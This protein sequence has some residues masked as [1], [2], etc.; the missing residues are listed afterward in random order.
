MW[1]S[2]SELQV[3]RRLL[4]DRKLCWTIKFD[5]NKISL[6][7]HKKDLVD[8]TMIY[9]FHGFFRR[10]AGN[11]YCRVQPRASPNKKT[12]A[13]RQLM[14]DK[15]AALELFRRARIFHVARFVIRSTLNELAEAMTLYVHRWTKKPQLT[16]YITVQYKLGM[17]SNWPLWVHCRDKFYSVSHCR[18][19]LAMVVG[20]Q[21]YIPGNQIELL[22]ELL[23][24][25][26]ICSTLAK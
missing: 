19:R 24:V 1:K 8:C 11:T 21:R 3:P 17:W 9:N 16:R 10:A 22:P 25:G 14:I 7:V 15:L 18:G 26:N 20:L 5:Q 12:I 23:E 6:H 4:Y 2:N 13:T